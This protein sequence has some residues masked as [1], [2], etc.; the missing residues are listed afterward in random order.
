MRYRV[1]F[2]HR[3]TQGLYRNFITLGVSMADH[4]QGRLG[5][6]ARVLPVVE[7]GDQRL[8]IA[9]DLGGEGRFESHQQVVDFVTAAVEEAGLY[10]V[11][12]VVSEVVRHYVAGALASGATALVCTRDAPPWVMAAVT[13]IAAGAG[14]LVGGQVEQEVATFEGR[15]HPYGAWEW[16]RLQQGAGAG[17]SS[18]QA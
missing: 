8:M 9:Y 14:A 7:A 10:A 12:A 16:Y 17:L 2:E 1:S 13:V 5:A 3:P 15:R 11:R 6:A 18:A 4:L